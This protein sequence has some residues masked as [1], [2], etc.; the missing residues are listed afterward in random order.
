MPTRSAPT[1]RASDVDRS[2]ACATLDE[3]L[4][5]GQLSE[6][7][8]KARVDLA[9]EAPTLGDLHSLIEDLQGETELTPMSAGV[10]ISHPIVTA[11]ASKFGALA[12]VLPLVGVLV[13]LG[14]GVRACAASDDATSALG[15]ANY[16]NP[17][18][19]ADVAA[20]VYDKTG[21]TVVDML[22]LYPD[23]V[24]VWMPAPNTAR[25][26]VSYTYQDGELEDFDDRFSST[27][28]A[29]EPQIDLTSVDLTKVAG[30][31]AGAAESL[32]LSRIDSFNVMFRG[33]DNGPE[34]SV[35]A[36]NTDNESGSLTFDPAG[37]F[38][39]VTP[40]ETD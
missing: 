10:A 35:T 26:Q 34:V 14:F 11:K 13:A 23:Y 5:D 4:A 33:M 30:I 39:R 16:Q 3:G 17:A 18:V 25:K 36:D 28:D 12:V 22:G 7:E 31:I 6:S 2:N 1:T 40:F 15:S 9:M 29:D 8:Y 32:N 27:R 37:N 20:A 19:V 21:T 24:V 38:L